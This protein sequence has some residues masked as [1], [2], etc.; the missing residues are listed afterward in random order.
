[1]TMRKYIRTILLVALI[2]MALGG[3]LLH[4]RVHPIAQNPSFLVPFFSGILSIVIVPLLFLFPKTIGYGYVLNGFL[5]LIGTII[6]AHFSLT[7]WPAPATLQ[8]VVFKT[9]LADI[10]ILWGKFFVG[11]ALFELETFG[12]DQ[13]RRKVGMTYRY[14]NM[15]WWIIHLIGIGLVYF[16]GNYF[17]RQT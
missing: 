6:M 1:M 17:W 11:K 2:A 9:L 8:T 3:F 12:Y 13:N 16:L 7:R 15:G 14:P 10:L 4:Y 5:T